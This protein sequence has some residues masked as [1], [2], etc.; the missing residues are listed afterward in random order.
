MD[1]FPVTGQGQP[2]LFGE[3][4]SRLDEPGSSFDE[5]ILAGWDPSDHGDPATDPDDE[6]AWL[7]SLPADV[8]AGLAARPP[9]PAVLCSADGDWLAGAARAGLGCGGFADAALPGPGLAGLLAA[10]TTDGPG[11]L[12]DEQL[13]GVLR[14][15]QRQ[16]SCGQA[17]LAQA[18]IELAGRRAAGSSRAAEHLTDEL[19]IELTLTGRSAGR[20]VEVCDGLGRLAEVYDALASGAIDWPRACVFVDELALLDDAAAAGIAGRLADQAAEW[21]TGQLRAALARAV[22]AADPGAAQRRRKQARKQARVEAW[23][24][25]SG[26]AALAGR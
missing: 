21:T 17:G 23:H 22:L 12:D 8:R 6:Q 5:L 13:A 3:P 16:V 25:P 10:A 14:G 7:A 15:W 18:V 20:L 26:N 2:D 11:G 9:V 4:G 24:E 1:E 19:A